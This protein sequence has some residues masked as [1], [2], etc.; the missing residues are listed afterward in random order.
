ME[1]Q[2]KK[3]L[4]TLKIEV[5]IVWV[6]SAATYLLGAFSVI[7]TG[8]IEPKSQDEYI[9]NVCFV[10]VL[11]IA[12][13][14]SML[15]FK[16]NTTKNL[17]RMNKDEALQSYHIW[18]A[19]RLGMIWLAVECGI[20]TYFVCVGMTGLFGALIA[21][22]FTFMCWPSRSKIDAYLDNLNNDN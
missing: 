21:F 20:V 2:I 17:R 19:V 3:L 22:I 16:L 8:L 7:P 13:P 15:M 11:L 10:S 9:W 4:A 6:L 12:V 18:S 1:N 5:I 14:G